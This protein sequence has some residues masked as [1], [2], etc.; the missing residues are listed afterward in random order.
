MT[1]GR[2]QR[3]RCYRPMV[4]IAALLFVVV[5]VQ[6]QAIPVCCHPAGC[7]RDVV[8]VV[9][10]QFAHVGASKLAGTPP[11]NCRVDLQRLFPILNSRFLAQ[12]R[13]SATTRSSLSAPLVLTQRL[14]RPDDDRIYRSSSPEAA[15]A[16]GN[17]R[18]LKKARNGPILATVSMTS[19][20]SGMARYLGGFEHVGPQPFQSA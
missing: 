1:R 3:R 20:I 17:L 6:A 13:A 8:P 10:R 5:A 12:R 2:R 15:P 18:H 11:A 9:G 16:P 19:A 7:C 14:P 4:L